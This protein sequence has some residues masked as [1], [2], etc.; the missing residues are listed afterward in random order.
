VDDNALKNL[1]AVGIIRLGGGNIQVVFGTYSDMIREEIVKLTRKEILQI[2]FYS[3]VQGHMVPLKEV[4]D[5]VF[6]AGIV[7]NGVA[8]IPDRGEVVSPVVGTVMIVYP[9]KHAIG[10]RTKEGLEVLLHVGIDTS[11][12]EGKYFE[13]F[14]K[15]GDE[16]VPG[17][18]LI[19]F[20]IDKV[21]QHSKSLATP[22]VITNSDKVK[23]WSFAPFKAV[24]KGQASVFS[25]TLKEKENFVSPGGTHV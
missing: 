22:M 18:M 2:P 15:E 21:K 24:K 8:F 1:G 5:P 3:P 12:L 7:G 4:P 17:Q 25:V 19:R 9:S 11:R 10:I 23:S 6:S 16:V 20:Q 13:T 14:V